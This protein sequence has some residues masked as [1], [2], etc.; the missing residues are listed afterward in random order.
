MGHNKSRA[1]QRETEEKAKY[2]CALALILFLSPALHA[3]V[4]AG[5]I[6]LQVVP[7]HSREDLE[8]RGYVVNG[9]HFADFDSFGVDCNPSFIRPDLIFDQP[10]ICVS[11]AETSPGSG[12][13]DATL[14]L[15]YWPNL[16]EFAQK[17]HFECLHL[18]RLVSRP[19]PETQYRHRQGTILLSCAFT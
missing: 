13:F 3:E 12:Q 19:L 17:K 4:K 10:T 14:E 6:H 1:K 18:I 5:V 9:S 7:F 15:V 2:S 8:A 16:T 11:C